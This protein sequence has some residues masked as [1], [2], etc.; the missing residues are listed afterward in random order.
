[1]QAEQRGA[2]LGEQVRETWTGEARIVGPGLAIT[3]FIH[4]KIGPALERNERV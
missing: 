3:H 1:M 4:K 2:G